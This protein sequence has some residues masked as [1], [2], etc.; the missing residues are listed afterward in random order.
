MENKEWDPFY[1]LVQ[2]RKKFS[3]LFERSF[4]G[5]MS[6]A[7]STQNYW[8]PPVDVFRDDDLVVVK[9]EIP[10]VSKKEI[11]VEFK[12]NHLQIKGCRVPASGKGKAVFHRIE[13]Q[14]G[15]FLRRL[16]L[17]E[18]IEVEMIEASYDLGVLTIHLPVRKGS[19]QKK[20]VLDSQP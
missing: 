1:E 2:L 20:I 18:P 11:E 3:E 4:I 12:D 19:R 13:R 8:V 10:G 14:H 17:T 9:A 5:G 15:P 7:D 6:D 16:S